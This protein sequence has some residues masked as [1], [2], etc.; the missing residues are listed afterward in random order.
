M[1]KASLL[2]ADKTKLC[3]STY[4]MWLSELSLKDL[5]TAE[6]LKLMNEIEKMIPFMYSS[7]QEI[8]AALYSL[9]MARKSLQKKT[10]TKK[11]LSF[12]RE[13]KELMAQIYEDIK[14][15]CNLANLEK[16]H[17]AFGCAVDAGLLDIHSFEILE[18]EHIGVSSLSGTF[19]KSVGKISDEFINTMMRAISD[20]STYPLFDDATGNL[21]RLGIDAGS[22]KPSPMRIAQGKQ[23]K[24][25]ADTLNRLPLFDEASVNEILDIR[26]E[27]E[28]CL[29]RFR[30][31]IIKYSEE[32]K[33]ASWD[34]EFSAEAEG[35]FNRDIAPAVR[36][37]E[38]A[39]KSNSSLIELATRKLVDKPALI[40]TSVF[41]FIVSQL[42]SFPTITKLA[43]A[44][45][46]GAATALYDAYK[47]FQKQQISTEQNQLYF[48]Y[49]A[50]EL[51]SNRAYEYRQE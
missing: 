20:A 25:A 6:H 30:S 32:I 44:A 34:A 9:R 28:H 2:Y 5:T 33:N 36:D 49:R 43:M 40:S 11:D 14:E 50:G 39:V 23:T 51:L 38:D 8:E 31:A 35:I 1:V 7:K 26:L 10:P 15:K 24:L 16:V 18:S 13:S 27:L 46:V 17:K 22:I 21:V 19:E 29:V 3:S 12:R 45:S 37:I 4:S 42:S 48:Y 41:S 47:E